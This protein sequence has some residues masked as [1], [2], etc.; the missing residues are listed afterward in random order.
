[1]EI[2]N[3]DKLTEREQYWIEQTQC[4]KNK[5]GYNF[6]NESDE[7]NK[8]DISEEARKKLSERAKER[9][10]WNHTEEVKA[11]LSEI[12]G[13]P[14]IQ[15]DINGNYIKEWKSSVEAARA[16]DGN[17]T[18]IKSVIYKKTVTAYGYIWIS[19]DEY[20]LGNFDIK[21]HFKKDTWR[22]RVV[23]LSKTGEYI[24]SYISVSDAQRE[25]GASNIYSCCTK[26]QKSS[27]GYKWIFEEEYLDLQSKEAI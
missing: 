20:D 15:L 21:E 16:L 13:K 11:F 26:I 18:N 12:K 8:K 14:I 6:K 10:G 27:G 17:E 7:N 9:T 1:V 2:C 3:S 22:R 5:Y 23:Q 24:K 4:F 19:K 25:T